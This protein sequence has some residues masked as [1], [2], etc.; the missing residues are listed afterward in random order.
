MTATLHEKKDRPNYFI[1]LRYK[2]DVGKKC[3]KWIATDI[4]IKGNNKRLANEKMMEVLAENKANKVD[5]SN[6]VLF[7]VFIENWLEGLKPSIEPTTYDAYK[8]NIDKRIIPFFKPQRLTVKDITPTH[9]QSFVN[10]YLKQVSGNTVRKY[11]VNISKCLDS[12]VRYNIIA[13]N[14]V[15]RIDLPKKIKFTGAKFYNEKQIEDLL[16]RSKGDPLEI[17]IL[18]AVFYGLRRSEVLGLRWDAID[19]LNDTLTIRHTVVLVNK[20]THR[21]DTTKNDSSNAILPMTEKT[22][23]PPPGRRW[24]RIAAEA[25]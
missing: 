15:K 22:E 1:L 19:M 2:N 14:P 17:T 3:Q 23:P 7:D 4:P 9:I 10:H 5:L 21:K 8:L 18:L 13:F 24:V 20:T 25:A 6:D 12:A 11:L 16:E